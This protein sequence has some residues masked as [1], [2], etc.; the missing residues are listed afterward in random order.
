VVLCVAGVVPLAPLQ[1]RVN[2][3]VVLNDPVLALPL[4]GL[5]PDH[6]PL[7][8]Q[9][10]ALLEDQLSVEAE[11]LLTVPGF[12]LK[13]RL[14]LVGDVDDAPGPVEMFLAG[15]WLF[16][17]VPLAPQPVS[18]I[19]SAEHSTRPARPESR[20]QRTATIRIELHPHS[21]L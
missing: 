10:L 5:L 13:V 11:P 12:A 7:A 1:V 21:T 9:L 8:V 4:V 19:A 3:V 20:R 6:P 14:G 2:V 18:A 16:G 15:V 17:D